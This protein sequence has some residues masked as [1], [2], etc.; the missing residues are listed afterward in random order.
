MTATLHARQ[1]ARQSAR[2]YHRLKRQRRCMCGRR[3]RA[4]RVKCRRCGEADKVRSRA[5]YA[6]MMALVNSTAGGFFRALKTASK[7]DMAKLEHDYINALA[8]APGHR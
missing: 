5:R 6:R 8:T 1:S 4:D 3:A 2:R 7:Q